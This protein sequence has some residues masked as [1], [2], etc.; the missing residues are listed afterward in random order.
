MKEVKAPIK[1][2]NNLEIIRISKEMTRP[3]LA[4]K[5]GVT[6]TTIYRKERS[7]RG[8]SDKEAP[9]YAEALGVPVRELFI[10]ALEK[11]THGQ[12]KMREYEVALM[13]ALKVIIL[14]I[15][16][17]GI[18]QKSELQEIFSHQ[19]DAYLLRKMKQA[20]IVM[21]S[22]REYVSDKPRESEFQAMLRFLKH[23]PSEAN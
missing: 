19:R 6:E 18:I 14:A 22:L 12:D 13:D 2:R 23:V 8:L 17:R 15:T 9:Q 11:Y 3:E 20:P 4:R 1:R 7:I 10:D 21:E 5:L 16:A